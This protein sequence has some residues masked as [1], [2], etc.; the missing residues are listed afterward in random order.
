MVFLIKLEVTKKWI[1]ID[2]EYS[3][4]AFKTDYKKLATHPQFSEGP[5]TAPIY[6]LF[7]LINPLANIDVV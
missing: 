4:D 2:K 7:W 1:E 3:N 5:P 6:Y